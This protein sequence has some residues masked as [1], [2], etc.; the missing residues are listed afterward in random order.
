MEDCGIEPKPIHIAQV[1][2]GINM[3][4]IL[5][6]AQRDHEYTALLTAI[7]KDTWSTDLA[8]PYRNVRNDLDIRVEHNIPFAIKHN[9]IIVPRTLRQRILLLAHR[10]HPGIVRMKR[11]L[12]ESYWWPAMDSGAE[13]Y[14]RYCSGCQA[15]SKT[16][17]KAD[18]A[19][20][21]HIPKPDVPW[22]KVAIDITGPFIVALSSQKYVIT[23]IDYTSKYV[24]LDTCTDITSA[25]IMHWLDTVFC[26]AGLPQQLI[27]DNGRQF[28]S[29]SFKSYLANRDITHIRTTPYH[30]QANGLVE[31][32]N[33]T[34]KCGIQAF[35]REGTPWGTGLQRLLTNYR[36]A[37]HG[38]DNQSPA[39]RFFGRDY[40]QPHQVFTHDPTAVS[41][42]RPDSPRGALERG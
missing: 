13:S 8:H 33:R 7:K 11:K 15:S 35:T 28:T 9:R 31:R 23:L 19:A 27:S 39:R 26:E 10:G 29:D 5:D 36:G 38:P 42:T 32:F 4:T 30:P 6:A 21:L 14:V 37:P 18:T 2:D 24:F 16:D 1:T 22:T 12:H 20:N 25:T 17:D 34:L 40:R 3:H 41:P